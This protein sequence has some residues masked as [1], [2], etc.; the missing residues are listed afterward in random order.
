MKGWVHV[1]AH[2]AGA[3]PHVFVLGLTLLFWLTVCHLLN[4]FAPGFGLSC[5]SLWGQAPPG[6]HTHSIPLK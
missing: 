2:V 3:L 6:H 1:M 5:R 4:P